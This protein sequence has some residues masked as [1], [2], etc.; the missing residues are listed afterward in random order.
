[1][2]L[3]IIR[4]FQS[5]NAITASTGRKKRYLIARYGVEAWD[6][7]YTRTNDAEEMIKPLLRQ[8]ALQWKGR[9]CHL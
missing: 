1:M 7:C 3:S 2:L 4:V 8:F 5:P 6:F 9:N